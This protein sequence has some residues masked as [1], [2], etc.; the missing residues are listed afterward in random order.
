MFCVHLGMH[1][2]LLE[3]L[4]VDKGLVKDAEGVLVHIVFHPSDQE[5]AAEAM[6]SGA[7]RIYL[8]HLPLGFWLRMDKFDH[9]PCA[10][11]LGSASTGLVFVEPRTSQSFLFRGYKVVRTAFPLSHARVVTCTACQ[12]RTMRAG[13]LIDCGRHE[14]GQT[15]K[16]DSDWWLDI[17]V[18]LSRAT[19]LKDLATLRAP[20]VDFLL[21]GPPP[22]L[23]QRLTA[24][25][26]R[27]ALCRAKAEKLACELG[28]DQFLHLRRF[29]TATG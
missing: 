24:F 16:E 26:R 18:M 13:V 15:K 3:A 23:R 22:D 7:E 25:A 21:S 8:K 20:P 28:F 1:M 19:C 6:A 10:Q 4:D 27:A 12:G 17:Y 11:I 9:N 5:S 2:R 14:S 29:S